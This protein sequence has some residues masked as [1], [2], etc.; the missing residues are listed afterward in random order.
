VLG[1]LAAG[2]GAG[3]AAMAWRRGHPAEAFARRRAALVRITPLASR[4]RPASIQLEHSVDGDGDDWYKLVLRGSSGAKT[5]A[6]RLKDPGEL[7]PLGRWVAARLGRDLEM[8]SGLRGVLKRTWCRRARSLDGSC[9]STCDM[10][11][12]PPS[13]APAS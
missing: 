8:G 4:V 7:E 9:A 13:L 11:R 5:L 2:V 6:H 1:L 3:A 12:G 10:K